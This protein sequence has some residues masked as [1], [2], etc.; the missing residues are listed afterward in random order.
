MPS[1]KRKVGKRRSATTN[2]GG[3]RRL[4]A[5]AEEEVQRI[6][7]DLHDGPVQNMFAA[8]GQLGSLRTTLAA[9]ESGTEFATL[10]RAIGLIESA[11][12]E[13]RGLLTTLRGPTFAHRAFH[14][15]VEDVAVE[16]EALTGA[17]VRLEIEPV[18]SLDLATKIGLYRI[19]QE[20]LSNVRRHADVCDAV[21]RLSA[22]GSRVRL[23]VEDRG[24]GFTPPR[25]T[26]RDATK[27]PEHIGLRGMSERARIMKGRLRI[28]SRPGAGTTVRVEVPLQ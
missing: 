15:I 4:L 5:V 13:I 10:S 1:K 20:S 23:D 26:G 22:S 24:R 8:M 3:A 9:R 27:S 28:A 14:Q 16:H 7:L 18:P 11:T 19:L 6:V 25:L 2:D 12:R 21:V 17:T